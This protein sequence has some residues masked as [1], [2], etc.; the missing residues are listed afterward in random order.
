MLIYLVGEE[1]PDYVKLEDHAATANAFSSYLANGPRGG[2]AD[3]NQY[4]G[5]V[6]LERVVAV[7][8]GAVGQYDRTL[9]VK[10]KGRENFAEFPLHAASYPKGTPTPDEQF[11]LYLDGG[12]NKVFSYSRGGFT[13]VI[14]L[15]QVVLML[16]LG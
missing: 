7:A 5:C 6:D 3:G 4:N 11:R 2:R 8:V 13:L 12:G 15:S 9:K 10:F 14:D 1:K 16:Y